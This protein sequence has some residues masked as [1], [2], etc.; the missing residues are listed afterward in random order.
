MSSFSNCFAKHSFE[1]LNSIDHYKLVKFIDKFIEDHKFNENSN[2]FD[3]GTNAGSFVKALNRF[4]I[5]KNIHCFE[6]HPVLANKVRE[7]Y[8]YVKLNEY[9]V[10]N[11]NDNIDI[12]IPELSTGLSSIIKRPVFDKLNQTINKLNTKC[13]TL[14]KYCSDNKIDMIDFIKIDVEGAEKMVFEGAEKLLSS[15]LILAGV[16]EIGETL[17][18]AGTN[19]EEVCKLLQSY[20]YKIVKNI[21][22]TDYFFHV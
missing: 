14:D 13:V 6:P 21:S 16:F 2:I 11:T 22:D 8:P 17:A 19:T 7:V 10:G 20:G 1:E 5:Y 9:C 18:D 4:G 15:K 3:I 12:Y